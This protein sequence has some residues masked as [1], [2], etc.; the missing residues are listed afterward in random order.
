MCCCPS[1]PETTPAPDRAGHHQAGTNDEEQQVD[2]DRAHQVEAR[3]RQGARVSFDHD[4]MPSVAVA[5]DGASVGRGTG[6]GARDR[7]QVG[8]FYFSVAPYD[9]DYAGDWQWDNDDIVIYDDPDHVGWYLAY[10]VRTGTYIHVEY[11][12][13]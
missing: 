7:F 5:R 6:G 4:E 10:N 9:Y 11:L 13:S 12:G 3:V 1:G 2:S 8:G